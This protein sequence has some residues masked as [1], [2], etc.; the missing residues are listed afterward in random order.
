MRKIA[1]V[2]LAALLA[3]GCM[4]AVGCSQ[5]Q[6]QAPES[7]ASQGAQQQASAEDEGDGQVLNPLVE[8]DKAGVLEATGLKL[9][10]PADATQGSAAYFYIDMGE[11][12]SPIAEL[13][14]TSTDGVEFTYRAQTSSTI[15]PTDISG[16]NYSWTKIAQPAGSVAHLEASYTGCPDATVCTWFDVVPGI[17]YS[18]SADAELSVDEMLAVANS[19][20]VPAQS[21]A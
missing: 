18:L 10:P 20:F 9:D 8:S 14:F 19:V 5:G 16:M 1:P 12:A 15:E 3:L 13:R 17:D 7:N 2:L 21:E 6:K 4:T 11:D